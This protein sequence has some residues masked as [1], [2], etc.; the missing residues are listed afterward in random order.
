MVQRPQVFALKH[1]NAGQSDASKFTCKVFLSPL[2]PVGD[3]LRIGHGGCATHDVNTRS[4]QHGQVVSARCK[5]EKEAGLD[6]FSGQMFLLGAT[7][8]W[9]G[10]GLR[11]TRAVFD[12]SDGKVEA[13]VSRPCVKGLDATDCID[14]HRR[15][16]FSGHRSQCDEQPVELLGV[17]RR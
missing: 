15:R 14:Q 3:V 6:G 1:V 2:E 16:V 17:H 7:R 4:H 5:T 13:V 11:N 8:Q 10:S 12:A 9:K